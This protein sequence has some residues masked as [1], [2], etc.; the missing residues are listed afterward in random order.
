M[1]RK[2]SSQ[3]FVSP[4][5]CDSAYQLIRTLY[6]LGTSCKGAAC[7]RSC[8]MIEA[9]CWSS[10]SSMNSKAA[11]DQEVKTNVKMELEEPHLDLHLEP[12]YTCRSHTACRQSTAPHTC[13][14]P[15]M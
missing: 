4:W 5:S 1:A 13:D 15:P 11:D 8:P 2:C 10:M 14:H 7:C 3:R 6:P 9:K 12:G